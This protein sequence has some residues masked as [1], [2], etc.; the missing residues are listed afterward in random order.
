[1]KLTLGW[2]KQH[3]ETSAP[4]AEIID[5]LTAIGLEVE[6]VHDP[7][8]AL[9]PFSV[10]EVLSAE[11]HPNADRL[12]LCRVRTNGGTVQ[13]VCGAPNARAGMKTIFA[14]VGSTIPGTGLVLKP[15][16][17]R[18]V[19]SEG[20]LCSARE[21]GISDE[22]AGILDLPASSD[23]GQPIAVLLG[24]D[25]PV[26]EI[27]LTPNRADCLGVRGI[28]RD[29][30]AA[31]LGRLKPID[32]SAVPGRFKSPVGL[33]I[34]DA[35]ASA[36]PLYIGRLVRGVTNG[37]SPEWLQRRLKAVGLRPISALVDVT[38]YFT[39][40]LARPLHVFD[41]DRLAPGGIMVRLARPGETIAALDG[42]T[43]EL[44]GEMCVIADE[45]G[46]Q[47]L[48]GVMGGAASGV[49]LET[50]NVF[51]ESA[52]FD[53]VRTAATGRKLGI[54]SDA[55]YR[56]ERGVDPAFAGLGME[57]ATR[58][59][60]DL[61]GGE[62]SEPVIA[63]AEPTWQRDLSFRPARV[64]QLGGLDVPEDEQVRILEGLGCGVSARPE[65]LDVRVP[66]WRGDL[67]EEADLV[68]E[69]AR[70]AGFDRIPSV[71]LPGLPQ[72]SRPA[73]GATRRQVR[74]ARR[75]L[76]GRGLVEAA[77]WSFTSRKLAAL[78]GGGGADLVLENPIS[79]ELDA[80]RPSLLV[81]LIAAAGRNVARGQDD[82]ALCEIGP[83]YADDTPEGQGLA[84]AGVRRGRN[85]PR[86]WSAA[87]R[88]V[89]VFDAKA[90]AL[91]LLAALGVAGDSLT[92]AAAAPS[93]Y[94]PGRSGVVRLGPKTM[95]ASFGALH[96]SVLAALDVKGPLVG[97]EVHLE[98]LP[99]PRPKA[100]KA[101]PP[102]TLT[103]LPAVERDF[104]FV[105][106]ASVPAEQIV[107]AARLAAKD[108]IADV[109]VFDVFTGEALG[110]ERKSVAL[111]VRLEPKVKTLTEAEIDAVGQAIIAAV[112]KAT[113]ATLRG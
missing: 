57:M 6:S 64:Q 82:V 25:D 110:P 102:L 79:A 70:I 14:P 69:V 104:A 3:L 56:F 34:A 71:P 35:A 77:T 24:L 23:V 42:R 28:A 30:Q 68:E 11:P 74:L 96:P 52:L 88:D 112:G 5:R 17:I 99:K 20:M 15:S 60:L 55:L 106:A 113:G 83:I 76:A 43:Y 58:L 44:D 72:V 101:R 9:K 75:V 40:D 91:A 78:F 67:V 10:A 8:A 97:F 38:N 73:L 12:K 33:R 90:D 80:M 7:A 59:I 86:H 31:G 65:S 2:L 4:P 45:S 22:H 46:L 108:L 51:I 92:V 105:V 95:L 47:G 66:S 109:G 50:A 98:A 54:L 32:E 94:H 48:G 103:E 49:T 63:G 18:G 27:K 87:S 13:V 100:T 16:T 39:M 29:L 26:L 89:D 85:Q 41:A 1:M 36:C 61:C 37:P 111:A 84:A 53:P 93:W 62:A 81:N 107:R 19:A 21:M